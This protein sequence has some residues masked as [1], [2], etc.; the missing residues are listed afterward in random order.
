MIKALSVGTLGLWIT[1]PRAHHIVLFILSVIHTP[2]SWLASR[3]LARC[4]MIFNQ[5]G[6]SQLGTFQLVC[7]LIVFSTASWEYSSW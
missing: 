6:M 4:F 3:Q 1:V 2:T 5:L 7:N